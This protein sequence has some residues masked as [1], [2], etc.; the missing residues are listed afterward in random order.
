MRDYARLARITDDEAGFKLAQLELMNH[1]ANSRSS[2]SRPEIYRTNGK[3]RCG[4]RDN[5]ADA[6]FASSYDSPG[7]RRA[8]ANRASGMQRTRPPLIEAQAHVVQTTDPSSAAY[9]RGDRVFHQKFG[10]GRVAGVEGNK[11]TVDFDKAGSKRVIDNFVTR[12]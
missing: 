10:Y 3:V 11:L 8:Q 2:E 6:G 5:T 12:A 9:V 4:F 7:W 1:A